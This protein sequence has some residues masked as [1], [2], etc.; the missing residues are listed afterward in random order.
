LLD[1]IASSKFQTDWGSR[2]LSSSSGAFDPDS[3]AKGS[4]F[5]LGTTGVA[6]TFWN[7]HR[8]VTAFPMW[9]SIVPWTRL[10]SLGHI[11]EV[12]AGDAYHQQTESVPEQTWS[13]AGLVSAAA[14]G[15]LGL[16]IDSVSNQIAF[17]PHMPPGW[18]EVTVRNVRMQH[19]ALDLQMQHDEE[20]IA[21]T[22]TNRGRP[23]SF[24]F[25]PQIPLGAHLVGSECGDHRLPASMERNAHDEH[26]RLAF[27]ASQGTVQCAIRF[28]GGIE[29]IAP[30]LVPV[31][32]NASTG[33][34]I[35]GV[36]LRNKSLIVDADVNRA[37]AAPFE[38]KTPWKPTSID[39][40]TIR[41]IAGNLYQID[42]DRSEITSD[43]FGYAHCR[44]V[45]RFE[46]E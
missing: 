26:A 36:E 7:E 41:Q 35:T 25:D 28:Q 12:L 20:N 18:H 15:L 38:I 42:L 24:V 37:E 5:A 16:R 9:T 39:G 11:H 44:A 23:A 21:L 43:A 29:V 2:G 8:P 33:T 31:L 17:S 13:S 4:V 14:R 45:V 22:V 1:S 32:G 6:E 10:D 30:D 27:T 46:A 40:G 19:A 3:Y 34:K